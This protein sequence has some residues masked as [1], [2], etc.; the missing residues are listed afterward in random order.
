MKY[1][2]VG[3]EKLINKYL[4]F[5]VQDYLMSFSIN[6]VPNTTGIENPTYIY[7]YYNSSGCFSIVEIAQRD[8]WTCF[9]SNK[10]T[11]DIDTMH[12]ISNHEFLY[13]HVYSKRQFLMQIAQ[14]IKKS[15]SKHNSFWGISME[16]QK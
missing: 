5:L 7:S 12:K 11:I 1:M 6:I 8:E 15:I 2:Y 9:F 3:Q 13:K 10:P 16:V 4:G 14:Y